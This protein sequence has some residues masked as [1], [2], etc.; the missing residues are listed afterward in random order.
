MGFFTWGGNSLSADLVLVLE[1]RSGSSSERDSLSEATR[2]SDGFVGGVLDFLRGLGD[3]G[4]PDVF[5]E[6]FGLGGDGIVADVA[7]SSSE[8]SLTTRLF[9][10]AGSTEDFPFVS[11]MLNNSGVSVYQSLLLL[12]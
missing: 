6:D 7:S 2:S 4:L 8:S 9:F 11:S 5:G 3:E 12:T 10:F 1:S